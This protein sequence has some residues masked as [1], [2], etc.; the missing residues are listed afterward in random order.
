M[1]KFKNHDDYIAAAQPF[2]QP[3]LKKI[4]ATFHKACPEVKET[5][6]W[7]MPHFEYKGVLG[8]M[9]AFKEHLRFGFWKSSIMKTVK[10]KGDVMA[11]SFEKLTSVDD[12]PPEKKLIAMIKEAVELNEKGI[13]APSSMGGKKAPAKPLD[14]PDV[15][16]AA[17]RKNKAAAKTW[18][19]FS[20]SAK[21]E[22]SAWITGA[23]AEAT[24]E[25]RLEQ[26]IEWIAEG[27]PRNWKYMKE[28]Q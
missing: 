12:L 20:Q 25:S 19:G 2:A 10:L 18:A 9:A 23:K 6:K 22:Y 8:G 14:V 13:K 3:I 1:G 26:A 24:R 17:I 15:L 16:A 11:G 28:W 21:N 27:K 4:R 7:S 5:F